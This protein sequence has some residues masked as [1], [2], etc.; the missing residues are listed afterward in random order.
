MNNLNMMYFDANVF[1]YPLIYNIN[2]NVNANTANYYLELLVT[3]KM[4]GYTCTLT[5]DEVF[6]KIKQLYGNIKADQA[7]KTLFTFPNL[8]FV[9]V[10]FEIISKAQKIAMLFNTMP[11]D[12]I[13][14]AC[15]LE[16]CNGEIISNDLH[17]DRIKGLKRKF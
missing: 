10:D 2:L 16:Y 13:H 12:A 5:W 4:V 3:G 15:A 8:N 11:R 9:N 14:A 17:F 1:I 7:S 6:Y